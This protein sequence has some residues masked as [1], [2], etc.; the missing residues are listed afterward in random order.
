MST[1]DST[2]G[3]TRSQSNASEHTISKIAS[4]IDALNNGVVEFDNA[5]KQLLRR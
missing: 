4:P 3:E 5:V 2:D 1:T